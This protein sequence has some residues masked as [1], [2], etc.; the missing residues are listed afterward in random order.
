MPD[1]PGTAGSTLCVDR[2][3]VT[4]MPLKGRDPSISYIHLFYGQQNSVRTCGKPTEYN[5]SSW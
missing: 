2:D 1:Q 4:Y 5:T 3:K